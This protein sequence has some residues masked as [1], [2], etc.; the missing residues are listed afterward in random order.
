MRTHAQAVVIG[1]GVI[2]SSGFLDKQSSP[3]LGFVKG[4]EAEVIVQGV[5]TKRW[6]WMNHRFDE[7]GVV[8]PG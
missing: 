8:L 3:A 6:F 7:K 2:G 4:D 5:A 1:S